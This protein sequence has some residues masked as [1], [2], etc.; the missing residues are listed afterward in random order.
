MT[1]PAETG[2]HHSR[3]WWKWILWIIVAVLLLPVMVLLLLQIDGVQNYL[4]QQGESYLQKKLNT[5]VKIGYLR[6]RGWQYLELR[7]VFVADT[8]NKALFYSRSLKVHY[9]LLSL[10]NNEVKIDKLQW[11][12]VLVNAYHVNDSTFNF[13]FAIDAFVSPKQTPDTLDNSSG[14][15]L[16]FLLK[17]I[18]LTNFTV[19]FDDTPGGMDAVLVWEEIHLDPDDLLLD[20]GLYSFRNIKVDGL[21]GY[22]RQYYIPAKVAAAAPPPQP[23]DTSTA[24]MHLL[25]KKLSITNSS[26]QFSSDGIGIN[27]AWKVGHLLLS[28]SSLDQDSTRIQVGE[29]KIGGTSGMVLL[30][31]G[32]DTTPAPVDTSSS[33]WKLV[34]TTIN[35][36][37][38]A[39]RYDNGA[40]PPK[41]AGP[42]PDYN[43]MLLT[44]VS[45]RVANVRYQPDSISAVLKSLTARDWSG[46]TIK[47]AN[48]DVLFTPQSLVLKNFLV[49]TNKS[50]LRKRIAVT[51]PSW[52]DVSKDIDKIGIDAE[53]DSVRVALGEWLGFVPDARKNK[54]FAPL[55]NKDLT[56][57]AILKGTLGQL[58]IKSFYANDHGGNIIKLENG[59][60]SH[61]TDVDKLSANLPSLY[62]QSGNKPLRSWLPPGTLPDTPRLPENMLITGSFLG[63]MQN[64]NTNLKLKSDYAN[65]EVKARLVNIMDS[66]RSSYTINVPYLHVHPGKLLLDTTYGW[67]NGKLSATGQGYTITGMVANAD[68]TLYDATY[69]G[70]TYHDVNV[71]GSIDKG[72]FSASGESQDTS[73]TATFAVSGALGDSTIHN[74]KADVDLV[75]ADLFTTNWYADP[76]TLIGKLQADFP[77]ITPQQIVGSAFLTQWQIQ[78]EDK[79][80]PLDTVSIVA[81]YD[82]LQYIDL[83]TPLGIIN[84]WGQFDYRKIGTAFANVIAKPL[85]PADSG[86]IIVPPPGQL[87]S[88]YASLTWPRS[89][90]SLA[91]GLRID[92]PM[93]LHG[94][95]NS[96]S[97]LLKIHADAP[98]IVYDSLRVDS[99]LI[100]ASILDTALQANASLAH[101]YHPTFPLYHTEIAAHADTGLVNFDMVLRDRAYKTKYKL[102]GLVNFLP[103]NVLELSLKPGLILNR[104]EWVVDE[105]NI[106][107][108]K[109]S[110]PDSANIRL[111]NGNQSIHLLTRQDTATTPALQLKIQD[112]QLSTLTALVATDTL[113]ANGLLNADANV[114]NWDK[115]PVI[116]AKLKIDSLVVKSTPLGTLDATVNN[117][118]PNQYKLDATLAGADNNMNVTGT[119][120][121]TIN[122]HIDIG[123]L[124]MKALEPFTMGSMSS[125]YGAISGKFDITG[126]TASPKIL[127]NMHFNNAG[128]VVSFLGAN[129][130]LPDEDI[131]IDEKGIAFNNVVIAD[132]L[133]N[134]MVMNGRINTRDYSRFNFNLN[135][136]AEN[137]MALGPQ[138]NK[139][140]W[141]WGPAFIDSKI[142]IRGNL[143]L[144]RIDATVKLRD[145]SSITVILPQ[146]EPGVAD[147]E[148][149]V[150]FVDMSN[151]VDSALL[152]R[153]DSIKYQNPRLKGINFS[154]VAEI[155]PASTI[156]IVIDEQN[157][158][159]V[160]AKGTASINATLDPSSKMSL[161]GRY[162]I[163]EGK[164]E[165]SLNQLIKRSFDIQKGSVIT[166]NGDAMNADLDIT[167][168]Y[169]V[170]APAIDLVQ[171]Q[172][173]NMDAQK[174]N[175]YKQRIPFEVYLMIKGNLKK[176]D[177]SFRL[178]MPEKERNDF[179][180]SVYN[181][182]KQ[183][184][185]VPSELNKQ[186][187]GLLVLGTFIPDDPMNTLDNSGG[188]VGQAARN[189]VSKILSQQLNNFAGNLIKGVDL[190]FDL[191]SKEDYSTGSAQEQTNLNIGASKNLFNDRLTVSVGSNIM[192]TGNQQSASSL[193]GDISVE[194][195]LSKDGRYRI[196]VYQ[197]NDSQSVIEGQL[198]ETG[199]A[200]M[201]VMDYDEFREILQR[202]KSKTEKKKL[203]ADKKKDNA[204]KK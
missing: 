183:I 194:Y 109:N 136:N 181:R 197:R 88:W 125:M 64:M 63:G 94:H 95:F 118:A 11:D 105:N 129:L 155:T 133:N 30:M 52:S 60:V 42:D 5:R 193:I 54:N 124:N 142:Q 48:M 172:L 87:L 173:G 119:Y 13:Q 122:A 91:P 182:I 86:K 178:D 158:D 188:G 93:I 185:Q 143:D 116:D 53:L 17:D 127:G 43:H 147:R 68:A 189:S 174:R 199:V 145:K 44:N 161:T 195:K 74:I 37:K 157:G 38:L 20:D 203:R 55:W 51:V 69:N 200:F 26:F 80:I 160:Q 192:L 201:L 40:P 152:R 84:T 121:S 186:V 90:E 100:T 32:K 18:S 35:L 196:R 108:L 113:L 198:V 98:K 31:P 137:F 190:N 166:F 73:I 19:R 25:L 1:E 71:Q 204:E 104:Q 179:D 7:D 202:S 78:T 14:T 150:E 49:Q 66:V 57:S 27:T 191:Q 151:P 45:T 140:Q 77:T 12:S 10:L 4:R 120:D 131:L 65:A 103:D 70:Y 111:S 134:E 28:N 164:Y 106:V 39:V 16:Q 33:P 22:F 58:N 83:R 112:F 72:E 29:L 41:A 177:I 184:N 139:E 47:K 59:Q 24:S 3:P 101:L 85:E 159:F 176:P 110:M 149:V 56:L 15:T 102:G 132:S 81:R 128:G 156:K 167:A 165:M 9:N 146:E 92:E 187:M 79:V 46:F 67:I 168:K 135:V 180:G 154:G 6:A 96:D 163:E 138:Q 23:A 107:R 50:V 130:H 82:S 8:T 75:K 89:L 36:E 144:P 34:A 126:T 97:S 76:L 114:R 117:P 99:L 148:G 171:D 170:N 123:N 175:T 153:Q 141:V 61:A 2:E 21:K 62:I 169:T 115:S 162:E